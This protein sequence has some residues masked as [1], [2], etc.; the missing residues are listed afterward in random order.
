M[1]VSCNIAASF[2]LVGAAYCAGPPF[3]GTI[4]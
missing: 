3:G 2:G 1:L 4:T